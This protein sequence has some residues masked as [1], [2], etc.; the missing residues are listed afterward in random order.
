MKKDKE[1]L[2]QYIEELRSISEKMKSP[3][4]PV[5]EAVSMYRRSRDI[6]EKAK[7]MLN[8]YKKEIEIL[9]EEKTID[10]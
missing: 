10:E 8:D 7:D 5:A 6:A 2:E 1:S 9:N 3:E 4:L